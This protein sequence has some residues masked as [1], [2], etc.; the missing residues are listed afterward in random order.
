MIRPVANAHGSQPPGD[1]GAI[2]GVAVA[3]EVARYLIPWGCF[4]DLAG[5][6]LGG[7]ICCH[8]GSICS[9]F[10]R[11]GSKCSTGWSSCVWSGDGWS[12]TTRV[13]PPHGADSH[14]LTAAGQS[15]WIGAPPHDACY[16]ERRKFHVK[17]V[18]FSTAITIAIVGNDK[19]EGRGRAL[20][21]DG[22]HSLR[23]RRSIATTA[24]EPR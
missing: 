18:E 19:A 3:D 17:G 7:W 12:G 22:A 23:R 20:H 24:S 16:S 21:V 14:A 15:A 4:G 8:V 1:R 10:R 9:S 6:P 5:D 11:S 2:R 13:E